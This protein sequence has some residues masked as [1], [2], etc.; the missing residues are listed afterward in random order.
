M[1]ANEGMFCRTSKPIPCPVLNGH[2]A[3]TFPYCTLSYFIACTI[4]R[5]DPRVARLAVNSGLLM[6]KKQ[7]LLIYVLMV[8]IKKLSK[9]QCIGCLI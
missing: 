4:Q 8:P 2:L 7:G 5:T 1:K 6:Y 9:M 3:V